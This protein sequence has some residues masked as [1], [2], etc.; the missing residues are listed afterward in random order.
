VDFAGPFMNSM[1]LVLVC[2]HSK[3]PEVVQMKT[4]TSTKT[5]EA[6]RMIFCRTGI[7][8]QIVSDN[9]PQFTLPINN[10]AGGSFVTECGVFL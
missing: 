8:K 10:L 4:T 5:I 1:F 2:A 3:W 6:L 9:G 7:P